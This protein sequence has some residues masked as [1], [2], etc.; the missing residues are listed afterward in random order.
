MSLRSN[1]L[2]QVGARSYQRISLRAQ[3][4]RQRKSVYLEDVGEDAEAD[5]TPRRGRYG[6]IYDALEYRQEMTF[7]YKNEDGFTGRR[8][9]QPHSLYRTQ[10]GLF[11]LAWAIA[12]SASED[13]R[14][15]PGWRMYRIT[16]IRSPKLSIKRRG[17]RLVKFRVRSYRQ[18][19]RGR[20]LRKV[21]PQGSH[22][23]PRKHR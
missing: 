20:H 14:D 22:G 23:Q 15:L 16:R 3:I 21:K 19:R 10:T 13:R 1:L 8:V 12:L 6:V 17:D 2:A 9:V 7:W 5:F 18:Y 4:I 11:L